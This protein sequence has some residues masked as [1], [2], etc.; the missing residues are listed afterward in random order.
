MDAALRYSN[1]LKKRLQFNSAEAH[2]ANN[3]TWFIVI[4]SLAFIISVAAT[5][6][7]CITMNGDMP[8]P[9]GWRMSMMWMRMPGE[10]WLSSFAGF[11][12]M[13]LAMMIAMMLP[14]ALPMFLKTKRGLSFFCYTSMGYFIAWLLAGLIFYVAGAMFANETMHSETFSNLVPLLFG[15]TFILTGVYQFSRLKFIN[16]LHCRSPLGCTISVLKGETGFK[17]GCRQGIAC[18]TCCF[19]LMIIQLILGIMNPFVMMVT[20]I[21]IAIE[22]LLPH[23]IVTTRLFGLASVVIGVI[24]ITRWL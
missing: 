11:M 20:A 8:M 1:D 4:C 18:C 19:G 9:G 12:L 6:Y 5:A 24:M 15:L 17:L 2:K 10:K 13:W 22:K 14:S 16:L 3:S 21:A 7:F 23:P